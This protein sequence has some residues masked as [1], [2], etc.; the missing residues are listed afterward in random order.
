MPAS[1]QWGGAVVFV[2]SDDE[3][4]EGA[5]SLLWDTYRSG[6]C[7]IVTGNYRTLSCDGKTLNPA[8]SPR[9]HGAPWG[10]LYSRE[11]W[12]NLEFPENLWFEDTVNALCIEGSWSELYI[13]APVYR[14]RLNPAGITAKSS[15][16]KR[17]VD[18]YWVTETLLA[19]RR[20]LGLPFD[21]ELYAKVIHQFGPIAYGRAAALS[22]RELKTYFTC[23]CA[24]VDAIP[25][26]KTVQYKG[27]ESWC[28]IEDAIRSRNYW[29]WRCAVLKLGAGS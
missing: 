9:N 8:T 26:F 7:D 25:E 2:D 15:K 24:L 18:H 28:E 17:G 13:D 21:S 1:M 27:P 29:K 4:E 14:Y 10:R 22:N 6:G 12:R 23:M 3:L 16:S 20:R 19:W 5:L 11:V